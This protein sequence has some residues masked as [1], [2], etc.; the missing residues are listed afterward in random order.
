MEA[1]KAALVEIDGA[2][3]RRMN[4]LMR[5]VARRKLA[6]MD[7]RNEK[8]TILGVWDREARDFVLRTTEC[9]L[10]IEK[11]WVIERPIV[12][13]LIEDQACEL[14]FGVDGAF[15]AVDRL[16]DFGGKVARVSFEAL[17]GHAP[18]I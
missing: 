13:Q 17:V 8:Q 1:V 4:F 5:E 9:A 16:V 15:P 18:P 6:C 3:D 10:L 14:F 11:Y 12:A 2:R 7:R